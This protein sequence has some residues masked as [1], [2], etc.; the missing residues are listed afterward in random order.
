MSGMTCLYFC[1]LV[2][3]RNTMA[4]L[5]PKCMLCSYRQP[6]P[7]TPIEIYHRHRSARQ[8]RVLQGAEYATRDCDYFCPTC[9]AS[10]LARLPYGL[11]ICVSTSQLH[12]FHQPRQPGVVCPP[13]SSHVD[14][15]TIPG[16]RIQ[17]LLLAWK[18]DYHR[19]P[20]PMRVLLV[21]GLNDLIKGSSFD[22]ITQQI[23]RFRVNVDHQVHYHLGKPNSFAV[24]PL[25]PA[26]RLVWFPDN[27]PTSPEYVNRLAEVDRLNE[28]IRNF[29]T[30]NNISQVPRFNIWG[31][32]TTKR[33]VNGAQVEFKTH[34]WNEWRASEAFEDKLHLTDKMRIKM[35][36]YV[37]KYFQG[38]RERNGE[39]L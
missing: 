34:R 37:V 30:F 7:E 6:L 29:N 9:Q 27:G 23:L 16:A 21:A 20:R 38:E 36:Q 5:P 24:A 11:D 19:Q 13:D 25:L 18:I 15:L 2:P 10:H 26:P 1:Q 17:D 32:R 3:N 14:W 8:V 22:E 28:W 12:E 31:T 35:G 4:Y 33:M 39:L